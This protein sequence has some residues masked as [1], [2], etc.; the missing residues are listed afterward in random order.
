MTSAANLQN[1]IILLRE[2]LA[3]E[4]YKNKIEQQKTE[5]EKNKVAERDAQIAVLNEQLK[6]FLKKRFAPS[7]EKSTPDQL[8]L[9]NEA[10]ESVTEDVETEAEHTATVKSHTRKH[11]PRVSI[12]DSFPR[13]DIIHDLPDAEKVCPH[14]GSPLKNIGSE[15]HEQ[16]DI[17]PA[18]IRVIRHKRL[19]YAC[20]CCDKHIVTADKPKQ[21]IEKSIASPGLLACIAVQKYADAL[22]LYR[23]SEMFKR[24]GIELDRTN[25]ANWMV[26]CGTLVQPLVNL[27][28]DH[29]H[30]QACI[31]M[32]ETTLQVLEE[33]GKSAQS[34]SYMWVMTHTG[35]QAACVFHYADNRGQRVPLELLSADNTA[36][37][38]DGY[39]WYQKACDDYNITRLGCWAHA[40]RKF[41]EAQDQQKKGKAGKADQALTYIQKLY[42]L[43][44]A[45][46]DKPPDERYR[47]RQSQAKPILEKLKTW[48]D[49]S[50]QTVAPKTKIGV[51]LVY[52]HNQ[53]D[54]LAAYVEDGN[55]P[56]DNNAAER[57]IRPFAIGRKNWMFSKS[58]AGA[59]AS[60]NL[61]SLLETAKLNELNIYDYLQHVFKELPNAK[62]VEK[63]ETML[64]WNVCLG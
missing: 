50:L 21:P 25:M 44:K 1:E 2:Q 30:Q 54:R 7:S 5:L 62:T 55:Y 32:D 45:L 37:M 10:E 39:E 48:A 24:I 53:W 6:Y 11:K 16:L 27:L 40:R 34:R 33:P 35:A 36:I 26:K 46:R 15:D 41:R 64:P 12:P 60:A 49:N 20:P 42:T 17:I 3:A 51:A 18:K 19:K 63:I 22:P 59:K 31:H 13:E 38:V 47:A 23:Q 14:D 57:A 4:K 43:E 29:L 9:F 8:G 28:I 52:L 56:I 61:Y 58:Q